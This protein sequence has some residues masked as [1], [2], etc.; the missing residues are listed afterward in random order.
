VSVER[1]SLLIERGEQPAG[2]PARLAAQLGF[3]LECDRLKTVL[4]RNPLVAQDRRENDA[5]HS[6]HLALMAVVLAEYAEPAVDVG[7]V[8]ELVL[9]HD[10]VEIYA[11]DT[12]IHDPVATAGQA[13]REQRAAER[14]FPLLPAD[15]ARRLRERWDEF[16]AR[17]TPEARFAK[18]LDRLQPLLLNYNAGGGTWHNPGVTLDGVRA[19][20]SIIDDGAPQLWA[21]AERLLAAAV[22]HGQLPG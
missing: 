8:V 22:A 20:T 16:E 2:V 5:E 15:Q 18:A 3:L 4:R 6:W 14:L 12:W 13:E 19:R 21:Y 7:R 11:G 9:V 10:L 17:R 1:E